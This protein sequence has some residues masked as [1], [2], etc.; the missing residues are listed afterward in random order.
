MD[1]STVSA[2]GPTVAGFID[3]AELIPLYLLACVLATAALTHRALHR[4]PWER[5][6]GLPVRILAI[7]R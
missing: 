4:E 2:S 5:D 3:L 6:D 7:G 1:F